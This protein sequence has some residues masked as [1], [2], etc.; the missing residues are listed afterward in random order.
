MS[1]KEASFPSPHGRPGGTKWGQ[2]QSLGLGTRLQTTG[3]SSDPSAKQQQKKL[4]P[5]LWQQASHRATTGY[6]HLG[7]KRFGLARVRFITVKYF[8][9]PWS[10]FSPRWRAPLSISGIKR[11][12]ILIYIL[13]AHENYLLSALSS[14][15]CISCHTP[16]ED[17]CDP[18]SLDHLHWGSLYPE[19][20]P[21][22]MKCS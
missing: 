1:T 6:F 13:T 21:A 9:S 3:N 15:S 12:N 7:F 2:C 19:V 18:D 22:R 11:P 4:T 17:L 20:L 14:S 5:R 10:T 16:V 8:F